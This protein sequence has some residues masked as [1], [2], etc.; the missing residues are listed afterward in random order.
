MPNNLANFNLRG[1]TVEAAAAD[2]VGRT[3]GADLR[4][5]VKDERA[6][7]EILNKVTSVVLVMNNAAAREELSWRSAP[8]ILGAAIRAV[9]ES[10]EDVKGLSGSDK[11]AL[12]KLVIA[13][14]V[15]LVDRGVDGNASRLKLPWIPVFVDRWIKDRILPFLIDVAVE[16]VVSY[17]NKGKKSVATAGL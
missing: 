1:V 3:F 11:L 12:V 10:V 13:N 7:Q 14:L 2:W 8:P 4:M 9:M 16:S 6:V 15:R 17:W 5:Q